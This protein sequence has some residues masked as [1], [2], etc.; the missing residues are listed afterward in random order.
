MKDVSCLAENYVVSV[1]PAVTGLNLNEIVVGPTGCGKTYSNAYPRLIHT[2]QSS[3]VVP[4]AKKALKEKF[5][6]L[7]KD[8][9]YEVIDLD[10]AHPENC[11]VGYDPMDYIHSDE[12]VLQTARNLVG[13]EPS[14]KR[15]G[16]IDP[17]WNDATTSVLAAEI[18][19]IRVYAKAEN[20]KPS[21]ADVITL[22]H[23]MRLITDGDALKSSL[24]PLFDDAEERFPG[25]QASE[26]WKTVR[27]NAPKTANCIHSMVNNALDKIFT[28]NVIEMMRKE[29]K[30][31]FR[32][33]GEKKVALFIT[34]SPMNLSLQNLVNLMYA[35]MFRELFEL[36]ESR[37]SSCLEVPVHIICDDFACSGRIKDFESYISIFRAAG[38]STTLLLQSESQLVDM[39]G[40]GGATTIINNCDTYVFMGGMDY[41]TCTSI[42]RKMNKPVH[43][44]MKLPLE[45]VV[46]FRRGSEPVMARR[47]Q[48]LEDPIYKELMRSEEER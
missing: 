33:L 29:K 30:V 45:Q 21:F 40:E 19:L 10:Y 22:H 47:Y 42:S 13:T 24:D 11:E 9:G 25:N 34:T 37:E 6:K 46:V 38:I 26:L 35:D 31:S 48:I 27:V 12:D 32:E 36:A 18:A 28:K 20:K 16:D 43:T 1:D 44:V 2:T 7:F 23:G 3:V 41:Q 5:S 8:R 39:Y 14:R 17:Y 4:I 15:N